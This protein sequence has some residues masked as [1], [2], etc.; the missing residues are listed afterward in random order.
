MSYA[1]D[2]SKMAPQYFKWNVLTVGTAGSNAATT[3]TIHQAL[4]N[5]EVNMIGVYSAVE[6]YFNFGASG[7]NGTGDDVNKSNDMLLPANTLT[8]LTVPKGI[9]KEEYPAQYFQ[10][11]GGNITGPQL[12]KQASNGPLYFNYLSTTTTTGAVRIVEC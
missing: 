1:E 6:I 2:L 10:N 12:I 3:N 11:S 4:S 7:A 9:R 8:F 5:T